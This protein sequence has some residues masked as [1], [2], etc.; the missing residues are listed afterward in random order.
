MASEAVLEPED[1]AGALDAGASLALAERLASRR[2][3]P[4]AIG[5]RRPS[6]I[7]Q[8]AAAAALALIAGGLW[9]QAEASRPVETLLAQAYS[10]RRPSAVR[11]PGGG[12]PSQIHTGARSAQGVLDKPQVL[13][14]AEQ[15]ILSA[16]K[17]KAPG[18]EALRWKARAEMLEFQPEEAITTL[19]RALETQP[20]NAGLVAELGAAYAQKAERDGNG[21]DWS[22]ALDHLT[23]ALKAEPSSALALY[24]RALV[25]EAMS[26]YREAEADWQRYLQLDGSS[27]WA[28]EAR[29]RLAA[30]DEKKNGAA[31]R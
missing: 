19:A 3:R 25:L 28:A 10:E 22:H 11:I 17:D 18:L 5:R 21:Q 8:S 23:L 31:S 16:L 12:L 24:N 30:L 6:W 13:A 7:W 2:P 4:V 9:W 20:G 1:P 14:E 15:R 27:E 29:K 26:M